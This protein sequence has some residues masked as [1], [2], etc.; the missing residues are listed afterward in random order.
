MPGP[1]DTKPGSNEVSRMRSYLV[2]QG[3]PAA[4]AALLAVMSRTRAQISAALVE[5]LSAR[6][7]SKS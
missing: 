2:S 1:K 3:I 5:W 4:Q 6:P 7:K